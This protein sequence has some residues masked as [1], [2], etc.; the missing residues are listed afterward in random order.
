MFIFSF[1]FRG[2]NRPIR[3]VSGS[4]VTE[5][6]SDVIGYVSGTTQHRNAPERE[7]RFSG[8]QSDALEGRDIPVWQRRGT[9]FIFFK[10][11]SS[12]EKSPK[13]DRAAKFKLRKKKIK[14]TK[15]DPQNTRGTRIT[16]G[17]RG[18]EWRG[19]A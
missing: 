17:A 14:S 3:S 5:P 1:A 18:W 12:R 10:N 2:T 11:V 16:V 4:Q 8:A 13:W 7:S 15:K 9:V 19:S 6:I